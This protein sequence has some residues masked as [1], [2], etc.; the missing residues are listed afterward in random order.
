MAPHTT[1]HIQH[2]THERLAHDAIALVRVP[3]HHMARAMERR[4]GGGE[5]RGHRHSFAHEA[6][7]RAERNLRIN[8]E[9]EKWEKAKSVYYIMVRTIT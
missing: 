4:R 5:H 3:V 1:G 6:Q 9:V 8:T 7:T 2:D